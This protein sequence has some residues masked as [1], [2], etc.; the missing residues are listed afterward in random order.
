MNNLS[1]EV[2][3]LINENYSL[4]DIE[5]KLNIDNKTLSE[6]L[7]NIR[8]NG[9]NL[10]K[11]YF[12]DGT[13][14]P[15]IKKD[16]SIQNPSRIKLNVQD[17]SLRAI[18]ISDLHLGSIY[19]DPKLINIVYNYA[20]KH[21]IHVIFN[22]G[23]L[24]DNIYPDSD[25]ILKNTT[26][27]SQLKKVLRIYPYDSSI[28]NFILYGNHDYKSITDDGLNIGV[29]LENKRYDLISLGFGTSTIFLKGDS[30]GVTHN[31]RKNQEL[32]ENVAITFKGHSHKSKNSFKENKVI[33]VPSLSN[34]IST[35]Y[36]YAPLSCFLDTEIIF[37]GKSI[38][39]VN[40]KQLAIVN[41]EIRLANEE[42][43]ILK[44]VPHEPSY[45]KERKHNEVKK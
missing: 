9:F 45:K 3:K 11:Q 20:I 35:S 2:I 19:D 23:D 36:E 25:Q 34:Y 29:F 15:T 33:F 40:I 38:E 10:Q 30:I 39:R 16:L 4:F 14:Y 7:K 12:S 24:I 43:L 17:S 41:Y 32:P 42:A 31:I 5:K 6:I 13:I 37:V 18:F 1:K 26:V 8:F 22:A 28:I 21:N 44:K 27:E